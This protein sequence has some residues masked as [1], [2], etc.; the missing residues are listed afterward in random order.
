MLC[1]LAFEHLS[2]QQ[3]DIVF[4]P[5]QTVK[6]SLEDGDIK[7]TQVQDFSHFRLV[8]ENVSR[9]CAFQNKEQINIARYLCGIKKY[10]RLNDKT[11]Y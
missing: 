6:I 4:S 8:K 2:L 5:V 1:C 3:P 11:H 9:G 7:D 10:S